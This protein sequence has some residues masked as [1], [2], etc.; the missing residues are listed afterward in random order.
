MKKILAMLLVFVMVLCVFASCKKDDGGSTGSTEPSNS[1]NYEWP[2]NLDYS[3]FD[4]YDFRILTWGSLGGSHWGAF[5]FYYNKDLQGD[6]V[7]DAVLERDKKLEEKLNINISYIEQQGGDEFLNRARQS[8]LAGTDDFDLISANLHNAATMATEG[9]LLD[10]MDYSDILNLQEDYWDQSANAQLSVNN[11]LYF[12]ISDLTLVD[13]QA[14]WVVYFVKNMIGTYNLAPDYNNNLYEMVKAGDWTIEEMF[15]MVQ[16]VSRDATGDGEMGLDDIYGHIGEQ[17]N[18][19]A[20]MV[21][22]GA[23]VTK[24]DANDLPVYC[25]TDNLDTM[26]NS[27]TRVKDIVGNA[28]YSMLS[29]RLQNIGVDGDLWVDGMGSMMEKEE[30]LFNVT[31]MNR[32][33]LFR[34]L[35][36]EFG[37]LPLPKADKSQENYRS[38]MSWGQANTVAIPLTAPDPERT[39]TILEAMTCLASQTTYKAYV[40][41]ALTY[42][43]L[44]DE[45]SADMLDIIFDNRVYEVVDIYKW[46][47]G[48]SS[49]FG[50][51]LDPTRLA[52]HVNMA[53]N[54]TQKEIQFGLD[55]LEAIYDK[56]GKK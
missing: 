23:Q 6:V 2:T 53:K 1:A 50:E 13:K 17:Y 25:F 27:W 34:G 56:T 43:Y 19:V 28:N 48:I 22:C 54:S 55:D 11:H 45:E 10:L 29:G 26:V 16:A 3:G 32:C 30:A 8:I 21:G 41:R 4:G 5:E 31:G 24:K 35:D 49:T 9:L 33:K 47:Q 38:G 12:T 15:R 20:L 37:I 42:K 14:T 39:A 44:R 36:C 40:D 46:G 51:G 18:Y 7:N 52:S